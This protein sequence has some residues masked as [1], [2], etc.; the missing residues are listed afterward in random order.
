MLSITHG[1]IT[2]EVHKLLNTIKNLG[3]FLKTNHE[4]RDRD[5]QKYNQDRIL[6]RGVDLRE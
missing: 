5:R 6:A 1:H 2:P 4:D 3:D